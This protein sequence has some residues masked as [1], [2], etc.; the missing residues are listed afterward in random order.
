ML[1]GGN[2]LLALV[3][4]AYQRTGRHVPAQATP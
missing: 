3:I 2:A 1:D 4:A